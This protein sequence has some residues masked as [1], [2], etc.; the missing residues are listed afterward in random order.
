MTVQSFKDHTPVLAERVYVSE[1]AL[2]IGEVSLA[3][4]VS[5]WP[6]TVIRGDVNFIKIGRDSNIQDGSVL[7]VTSRRPDLPQGYPLLIG[8]EVTVGHRVM[9]HGC[10]I[11]DRCLIGMGTTVMD[12][13][14]IEP[15][16]LLAAGSLV[17][18]N[19]RLEGGTL[20]QGR[21]ARKVRELTV[22]EM[23]RFSASAQHYV[24]LKNSYLDR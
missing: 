4:N 15:G 5:I 20:Y 21:P 7:H 9:L 11:G 8:E 2:V 14:I 3:D 16:V 12:N 10:T 19:K 23:A 22:E 18:P 24:A 6:M 13:V 17:P 1:H